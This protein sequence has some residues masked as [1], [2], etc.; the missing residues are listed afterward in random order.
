MRK[1]FFSLKFE[2]IDAFIFGICNL[3]EYLL[4]ML[5]N[6]IFGFKLDENLSY[7]F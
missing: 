2:L 5:F 3:L 7:L 4:H 6:E 1:I